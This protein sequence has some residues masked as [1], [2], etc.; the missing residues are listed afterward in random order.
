MI[1]NNGAQHIEFSGANIRNVWAWQ[2][3]LMYTSYNDNFVS[4]RGQLINKES[5]TRNT[6]V[7][8][9]KSEE[10]DGLVL[11]HLYNN[12]FHNVNF[13]S[14]I[15]GARARGRQ[16]DTTLT[17]SR[18]TTE[19]W[20]VSYYGFIYYVFG[21][22]NIKDSIISNVRNGKFMNLNIP[23]NQAIDVQQTIFR[24]INCGLSFINMTIGA[25]TVSFRNCTFNNYKDSI[26]TYGA[27]SIT[28]TDIIFVRNSSPISLNA[29][30]NITLT[31]CVAHDSPLLRTAQFANSVTY[32]DCKV[33]NENLNRSIIE[34]SIQ[35]TLIKG[36]VFEMS[37][38]KA[39]LLNL[40][41]SDIKATIVDCVFNGSA[42]PF[43]ELTGNADLERNTFAFS[44]SFV[45]SFNGGGKLKF[46]YDN[47]NCIPIPF[48]ESVTSS[49]INRESIVDSSDATIEYWTRSNNKCFDEFI[50]EAFS[51]SSNFAQSDFFTSTDHFINSNLMT[52]SD[53]FTN[54]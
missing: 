31:N 9:C 13:L 43:I 21:T 1:S 30:T 15:E 48:R 28:M 18:C 54:S 46:S 14:L 25:R 16:S 26:S 34:S 10:K 27:S 40:P 44:P 32:V 36:C 53:Y 12:T 5:G 8:G 2:G 52:E 39:I 45:I 50:S 19:D 20:V 3:P 42:S 35:K 22:V 37:A 23:G 41:I 11:T 4:N 47:M 24:D 6:T 49:D 17:I 7:Q 38:G 33:H 29:A 51:P